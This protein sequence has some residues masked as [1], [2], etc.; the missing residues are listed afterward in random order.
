MV[1]RPNKNLKTPQNDRVIIKKKNGA[2]AEV[3]IEAGPKIKEKKEKKEQ[4]I[5]P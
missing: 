1:I 4:V 3:N 5:D 2:F